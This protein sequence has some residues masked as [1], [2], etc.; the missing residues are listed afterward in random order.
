MEDPTQIIDQHLTEGAFYF[1]TTQW[2]G[3]LSAVNDHLLRLTVKQ[4]GAWPTHPTIP[5][6]L[7]V[8]KNGDETV[9]T[10]GTD[11]VYRT[12]IITAAETTPL[13]ASKADQV[14]VGAVK[15][16][17]THGQLRLSRNDAPLVTIYLPTFS[18]GAWSLRLRTA[19]LP[20]YFG[21][22]MQNGM[23][24]LND[25]L[26]A[27]A[28]ENRWTLGGVTSPVPFAWTTEG[29]G[30]LANTF[31]KGAYDF[32]DLF[33]GAEFSHDDPVCDVYFVIG[34]TPAD[35]IRGYFELTGKPVRLP[36][37]SFYPGHFNAYNRDHWV[38][39]TAASA[40]AIQFEDG[41]WYKEYQPISDETFNTGFR[42]GTITVAGQSLVPNVYGNGQVTFLDPDENGMPRRS[43]RETLNGEHDFQFSARAVIERYR[44]NGFALGWLLP[45]DGYGAGYGQTASFA[46]DLTNLRAFR[47]YAASRGIATGLWTQ[48]KLTPA[49]PAHPQKGERDL[50]RELKEAG[51]TA[52]KTDVAWVG[53]GYTFGLNAT[54][55]AGAAMRAC[56]RR[57]AI[58]TVDGWAGSQRGALVWS[59]DQA[60]SNWANLKTHIGSYLS[61]SLSGLVNVASDVDG[62][63]AGRDPLI[64]LRDLQWKALTPHFFAMDGWGDVPKLLGQNAPAPYKTL[65]QAYLALHTMLVPYLYSLAALAENGAP[66]LRPTWW[67]GDQ[68]ALTQD[69]TDQF[70]VGD[71]LL[72][73]PLIDAY[74]LATTGAAKRAHVYLPAGSWL[75]LQTGL[76]QQGGQT[77]ADVSVPLAGLPAYLRTG[78]VIPL[79]LPHQNPAAAQPDLIV[80]AV[81]GASR[82]TTL[83]EDDGATLAYQT[84]DQALITLMTKAT[85]SD[86]SVTIARSQGKKT[87]APRPVTIFIPTVSGAAELSATLGDAPLAV[88]TTFGPAPV[89]PLGRWRPLSGLTIDCGVC[90]P[91][92]R[93]TI[94]VAGLRINATETRA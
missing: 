55:E 67:T 11:Q 19:T 24:S 56:D 91:A 89:D 76:W 4:G 87:V 18:D 64:A 71:D 57:P 29:F 21:G 60:G 47:D 75:D 82:T 62:I 42:R 92:K 20:H 30:L 54:A 17:L 50:V 12:P 90:D 43:I 31:T 23:V 38:A 61:A 45:N 10:G 63:Y 40:G 51:I 81:P 58:V 84:G 1:T 26:I 59:G 69:L 68:D 49:D 22:G 39:V 88:H 85:G 66:V 16:T 52:L 77:L 86:F 28:T 7:P 83:V 94:N 2:Q 9:A 14:S 78:A 80:L 13:T 53:E 35:M 34:Q 32:S 44:K 33:R 36:R 73:A 8:E 5:A 46:G 74:G 70:L 48:K 25:R 37:F 72:V 65:A 41:N 93:L 27:I 15:L 6:A 79:T 3:R